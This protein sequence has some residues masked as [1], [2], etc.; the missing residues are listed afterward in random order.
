MF[1]A[2]EHDKVW[3]FS[4][5]CFNFFPLPRLQQLISAV[6]EA[7]VHEAVLDDAE[8]MEA[9][10]LALSNLT[11]AIDLQLPAEGGRCGARVACRLQA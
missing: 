3:N 1:C 5:I 2:L 7:L 6:F 9:M 11:Q 8:V 4:K 10:V